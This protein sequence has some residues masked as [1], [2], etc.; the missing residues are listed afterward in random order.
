M[1]TTAF[2]NRGWEREISQH[3]LVAP[4]EAMVKIV[5]KNWEVKMFKGIK[6]IILGFVLVVIFTIGSVST[7]LAQSDRSFPVLEILKA[8]IAY[9]AAMAEE[10]LAPFMRNHA[11]VGRNEPC[12][13]DSG[14]KYKQCHGSIS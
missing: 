2:S 13:C 7:V 4:I 6:N 8:D 9:M 12:P 1:Y 5:Q 3:K 10:K 11:K 14:K